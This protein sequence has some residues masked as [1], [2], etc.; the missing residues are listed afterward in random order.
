MSSFAV[1]SV[2]KE[3]YVVPFIKYGNT[4]LGRAEMSLI[5][6]CKAQ[7]ETFVTVL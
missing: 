5:N 2:I 7:F 4:L 6:R 1:L 3:I